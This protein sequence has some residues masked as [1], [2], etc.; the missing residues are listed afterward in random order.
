LIFNYLTLISKEN[1]IDIFSLVRG[2]GARF[3]ILK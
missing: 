1:S 3:F 2:I